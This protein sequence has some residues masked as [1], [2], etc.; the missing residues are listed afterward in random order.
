MDMNVFM[1][2]LLAAAK[3]AGMEAAEVYYQSE[4][5]F[6]TRARDGQVDSY[7]VSATEGLSLR[8]MV[9]GRMGYASTEAFDDEAVSQLIEGV[10]E[11]AALVESPEQDEIFAGEKEYPQLEAAA[12][13]IAK[14]TADE[15][16]AL[17]LELEKQA[18]EG[19]PRVTKADASVSTWARTLRLKNSYGLDLS[20]ERSGCMAGASTI[21]KD[22]DSTATG[23]ERFR[24]HNVSELDVKKVADS[25]VKDAVDQ[26]HGEPVTTGEY[27]VIFDRHAMAAL[28]RTFSGMFSAES[29]QQNMSLL[30][31]KEG[32]VIAAEIVTVMDDPLFPGGFGSRPF[33]AEGSASR[34]KAV[35]DKGVLTTL[36]H[37]RKTAKK[38]GVEPTGNAGRDGYS[39]AVHVSPTNLYLKP[40]EKTLEEL[41]ADVGEGL[42]ITSLSGLHAGAN[43][44]S[45]DF[46]LLS[47]GYTVE[48]G[49]RGRAVERV[50]VAGNFYEVLKNIRA[51]GS[52]LELP[53]GGVDSPSVDAGVLKVSGK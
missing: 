11:A 31:G 22:G 7:Q 47:N 35:I 32:T 40:G 52:D 48:G 13:D 21:A 38:Q 8:G 39:G 33:D 45:G 37:T 49:K 29:A 20:D 9:N 42:V 5:S 3:A 24:G 15:K 14:V 17:C 46:S 4:E 16:L 25:A 51:I 12:S 30:K 18:R 36:L 19:D 26:L 41:M 10:K 53:L 50:T 43:P 44:L 1:D 27:R 34:T 28:L 2:K 23:G 6:Q